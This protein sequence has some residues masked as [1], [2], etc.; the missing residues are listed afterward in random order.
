MRPSKLNSDTRA[1]GRFSDVVW[2][3]LSVLRHRVEKI[4]S[5]HF[6]GNDSTHLLDES[7]RN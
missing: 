4:H 5:Y 7:H 6:F 3:D 2:Y 1:M